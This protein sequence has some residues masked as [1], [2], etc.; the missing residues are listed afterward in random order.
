MTAMV[1]VSSNSEKVIRKI[2]GNKPFVSSTSHH[3]AI[4]N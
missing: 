1:N 2:S 3:S 4:N